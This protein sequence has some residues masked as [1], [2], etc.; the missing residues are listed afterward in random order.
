MKGGELGPSSVCPRTPRPQTKEH[1][2]KKRPR[3]RPRRVPQTPKPP[4]QSMT[5][6]RPKRRKIDR[7]PNAPTKQALR[8]HKR[9]SPSKDNV[10]EEVPVE[11]VSSSV[12]NLH[13]SPVRLPKRARFMSPTIDPP[14]LSDVD[15]TG[16]LAE[17]HLKSLFLPAAADLMM[18]DPGDTES[19]WYSNDIIR[20]AGL[21]LENDWSADCISTSHTRDDRLFSQFLRARSPSLLPSCVSKAY[22]VDTTATEEI[23]NLRPTPEDVDDEPDIDMLFDQYLHSSPPSPSTSAKDTLNEFNGVT[24]MDDERDQHRSSG[25]SCPQTFKPSAPEEQAG[26]R[27]EDPH[28]LSP[29]P[30]NRQPKIMLRLKLQDTGQ[31]RERK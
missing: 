8:T 4:Q 19:A 6:K 29:R 1:R 2:P 7:S 15:Q 10:S 25:E 11:Y 30:R 5:I 9:K 27:A 16:R 17:D 14:L 12:S 23:P 28:C 18:A 26:D 31:R 3:G 13:V 24:L 22:S 20:E 21:Q